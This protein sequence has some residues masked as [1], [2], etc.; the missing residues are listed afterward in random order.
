MICS[1]KHR[2]LQLFFVSGILKGIPT[3]YS[4]KIARLLDA[5]DAALVPED[6]NVVGFKFHQLKGTR[7]DV[8]SV[9][10]S[11]N[12]RITFKFDNNGAFNINLEDY[13]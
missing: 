9:S 3:I 4:R 11:G 1:F 8:Y 6:M 12:W 5:L 2:G 13:H 7:K 10:V